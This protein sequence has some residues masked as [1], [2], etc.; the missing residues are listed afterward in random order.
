[1]D[2]A[3][4]LATWIAD[5]SVPGARSERRAALHSGWELAK[6]AAAEGAIEGG[7]QGYKRFARFLAQ[8]AED[9]WLKFD[10]LPWPGD[11][12]PPQATA[13]DEG[14]LQRSNNVRLTPEGWRAISAVRARPIVPGHQ[15]EEQR[16]FFISHASEDKADVARPLADELRRRNWRVWFDEFELTAGDSL[17]RSI[18]RGLSLSR[19]GVVILSPSFFAKEW[20][21]RE[22][23]GLTAKETESGEKV[24]LPIWHDV[25][26]ETVTRYSPILADKLGLPSEMGPDGLADELE[27]V[28]LVGGEPIGGTSAESISL[29]ADHRPSTTLTTDGSVLGAL[30]DQNPVR[31]REVLRRAR[32]EFTAPID[33]AIGGR[34]GDQLTAK[35]LAELDAVLRPRITNYAVQLLPLIDHAPDELGEQLDHLADWAS[36][37]P[38]SGYAGWLEIPRWSCW[39]LGQCLGTYAVRARAF[40]AVG[41]LLRAQ[42]T[43]HYGGMDQLIDGVPGAFG[44][45]L[46]KHTVASPDGRQWVA[47]EWEYVRE[48]LEEI[49]RLAQSAAELLTKDGDPKRAMGDWSLIHCLGLGLRQVRSAAYFSV[50]TGGARELALRLHGDTALRGRL[51]STAYDIDLDQL[52]QRAEEAFTAVHDLGAFQSTDAI[53]IFLTGSI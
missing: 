21:Q 27:R 12:G 32:G 49:T 13:F 53:P 7:P 42:M 17:R 16:H 23:D 35:T 19:F 24:V 51:A 46:A 48:V 45:D 30:L 14:N 25:D 39:C 9:G 6:V 8:L 10:Y 52:N 20:P 11:P 22:L 36:R 3:L 44:Y 26:V 41:A 43:S 29:Y 34:S 38:E 50:S 4:S 1:M 47:P 18:D 15:H 2:S 28:L 33:T 37:E 5:A 40:A 31:L